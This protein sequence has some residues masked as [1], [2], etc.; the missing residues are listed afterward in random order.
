MS[1]TRLLEIDDLGREGLARV[2]DLA[3]RGSAASGRPLAGRTVALVFEKPSLR[4]RHSS[5]AAVVQLGGH[6]VFTRGD[7]VSFD[8]R[9][10]VEDATRVLSGY[11][12][13][14][15]ARVYDHSI[16]ERMASVADVPVV[17]LLSDR[18]HPLQA[19][20][21]LLTMR[22]RFERLEALE[23]AWVGDFNN[24][25][26]SLAV[27]LALMGVSLRV[28]S[29]EGFGPTPADRR[30]V[31]DLGLPLRVFA[32][33]SEAVEGVRAVHTDTWVSMG[34]E[35]EAAARREVF[36][37]FRV[38][39]SLMQRAAADAVFMHCMPAHRG[40]EVA[41]DVFDGP[42]SVVIEQGHAR[43]DAARA[44]FAHVLEI[45]AGGLG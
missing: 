33:P 32:T 21:D 41:A 15:A 3:D 9:E 29:P 4:T 42:A 19:V 7:E 22:R 8:S 40:E 36:A 26:H 5:E 35:N 13:I 27:G 6:P 45:H 16:L 17:N 1:T 2:L 23:V 25:A 44:V 39:A 10:T 28:S 38:T 12:A 37:P 43:L 14:L 34:Q 20:A 18:A 31:A 11:H 30:L 24:V